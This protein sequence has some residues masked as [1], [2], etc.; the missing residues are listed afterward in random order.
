MISKIGFF[1]GLASLVYAWTIYP[2]ILAL[3]RKIRPAKSERR[4][5]TPDVSLILTTFNESHQIVERIENLLLLDYPRQKLE[6]IVASDGSTDGTSELA[7]KYA[8]CGITVIHFPRRRG[9]AAVHNDLMP[10]LKGEIVVF[11]DADVRFPPDLL[12]KLVCPF[13]D[14]RVGCALAEIDFLNR[15]ENSLTRHRGV[16]W[17]L[18][19]LL[20]RLESELG[21]LAIGSGPCMAVR[22]LLLR[23]MAK[24]TYDVDFITPLDVVAQG[25]R[26][27]DEPA[28][29]VTDY[30]LRSRKGEFRADTRMVAK[31]FPGILERWLNMNPLRYPG[32]SMSLISHKFLRWLSPFFMLLVLVSNLFLMGSL[33]FR[34]TITLQAIF[35]GLAAIGALISGIAS[36]STLIDI[37]LIPYNFCLANAA[38]LW[39]ILRGLLG[40]PITAYQNL[41]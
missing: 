38:F 23:P 10:N 12:R 30:I 27:V 5:V 33:F 21:I 22:R 24:L 37:V 15:G 26:V 17:R 28:A 6:I 8:N 25:C 11:T 9:K 40:R 1:T 36:R 31:N 18:E 7:R 14:P 19:F 34:M 16:Y 4:E 41:K 13:A 39:G 29:V 32:V 2:L 20:R 35:Y 3:W